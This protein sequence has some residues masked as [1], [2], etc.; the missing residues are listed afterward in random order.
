MVQ[1]RNIFVKC[2]QSCL[3]L[4]MLTTPVKS[5]KKKCAHV[6][7]IPFPLPNRLR[8]A[9]LAKTFDKGGHIHFLFTVNLVE[10]PGKFGLKA[11]SVRLL[12][13]QEYYLGLNIILIRSLG[14][15]DSQLH[16]L[17]SLTRVYFDTLWQEFHWKVIFYSLSHFSLPPGLTN[18]TYQI[19]LFTNHFSWNLFFF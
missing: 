14:S 1:P 8:A 7:S 6:Q 10:L 2:K 16:Q 19:E 9:G 18:P 12:Q 11:A 15:R 5:L 3:I 17:K 4:C 13:W